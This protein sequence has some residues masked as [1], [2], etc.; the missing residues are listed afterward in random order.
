VFIIRYFS[1]RIRQASHSVQEQLEDFSG[2]LQEKIAGVSVVKS[3]AR[4][5]SE[6]KRFY[7]SSRQLY[8]TVM[9]NVRLSSW[10]TTF[11]DLITKMA[12]LVVVWVASVMILRGRLTV[13][14]LIAFFAYVGALYLPLQRF[15]EL[16]IVI[17]NSV[18]AIERIFEF[19]DVQPEVQEHPQA[20]VLPP[21]RGEVIFENVSFAYDQRLAVLQNVNLRVR[22]GEVVALVGQS[23]S[24]KTTLVSLIPRFYD[25]SEGRILIDGVNIRNVTLKSLRNQ[26]GMVLQDTILFSGTLR[27]NLRYGNP[28]ASDAEL[29]RAA[30]AANAHEFIESLPEGY[31]TLIGERG[32]RLSGGQRQRVAIARAFLKNPRILILDEA[33]SALDSESEN[34]IHEALGRLMEGR[35]TFIIAHRLSTVMNADKLVVLHDGR[36]VEVGTHEELLRRGGYYSRLFEEQFRDFHLDVVREEL[37]S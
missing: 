11:T 24:G 37:W 23:G 6:A 32:I 4:E 34:L 18:A 35:T 20:V 17:S 8:D 12:P 27:E 16:G 19:F 14:T 13:G 33:T 29:I 30:Q 9:R 15:S 10:N 28:K 25:V 1:P 26:I 7:R 36:V 3:F 5:R 31:D 2:E 21:V 22:S